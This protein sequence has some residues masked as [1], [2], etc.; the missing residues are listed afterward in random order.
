MKGKWLTKAIPLCILLGCLA[1]LG[2]SVGNI[3]D[4]YYKANSPRESSDFE[5]FSLFG[6]ISI[7]IYEKNE[8]VMSEASE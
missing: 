2:C 1:L 5:V 7:F 8:R 4:V 3:A 6:N